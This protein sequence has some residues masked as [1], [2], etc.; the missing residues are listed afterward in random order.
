M[1]VSTN[2]SKTDNESAKPVPRFASLKLP[3]KTVLTHNCS[4]LRGTDKDNSAHE[5][6]Y[7]KTRFPPNKVG[8]QQKL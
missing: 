8:L 7:G 3:S 2:M 1:Y 4:S 6:Y 5:T